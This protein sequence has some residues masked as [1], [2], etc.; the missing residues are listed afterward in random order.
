MGRIC[1]AGVPCLLRKGHRS[2]QFGATLWGTGWGQCY[3]S[4][5]LGT[6]EGFNPGMPP[7]NPVS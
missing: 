5:S 7:L 3:N 4:L 6:G 1:F 2:R